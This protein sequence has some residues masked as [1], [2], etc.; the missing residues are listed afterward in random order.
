MPSKKSS[1]TKLLRRFSSRRV[2]SGSANAP[3]PTPAPQHIL[4]FI[5]H[6]DTTQLRGWV[7]S[8]TLGPRPPLSISIDG[9]DYPLDDVVSVERQDVAENHG[10]EYL[11]AGFRCE[12]GANLAPILREALLVGL[13]IQVRC[14]A[15]PLPILPVLRAPEQPLRPVPLAAS[16]AALA[17]GAVL[18]SWGHFSIRGRFRTGTPLIGCNGG[19]LDCRIIWR[20]RTEDGGSF[21]VELPGC[22]WEA[23][24]AGEDALLELRVDTGLLAEQPL[25]L[26]RTTAAEWI[27]DI[28]RMPDGTD[29]QY[30]ALLALEHTHFGAL[31]PLLDPETREFL[32]Q[33]AHGM[34]LDDYLS[35]RD[36]DAFADSDFGATAS[37]V[38][39]SA[40]IRELNERLCREPGRLFEHV[41]AVQE[42]QRLEGVPRRRFLMTCIAALCRS[43]ELEEL[44]SLIDFA[45]LY[46]HELSDSTWELSVVT[47]LMAAD[48]L[49][50]KVAETFARLAKSKSRDWLNTECIAFAVRR[51]QSLALRGEIGTD[52]AETLRWAFLALLDGFKGDW[53]SRL[54]DA[55]LIASMVDIL[56]VTPHCTDWR[57]RD[58]ADAAI[59]HYGLC[60]SFWEAL[61]ALPVQPLLPELARAR[62]LFSELQS[63]LVAP[64]EPS[65]A[66]IEGARQ[67]LAFFAR[68]NNVD[69]LGCS[70]E[71]LARDAIE[72]GGE[73][74]PPALLLAADLR[75]VDALES[76]RIAAF[77]GLQDEALERIPGAREGV[78]EAIRKV[79]ERP[80]S[81]MYHAQCAAH[82]L[83]RATSV[84]LASADADTAE[85]LLQR[86]AEYAF[87][88]SGSH[89]AALGVDL[90]AEIRHMERSRGGSG[91]RWLER[92]AQSIDAALKELPVQSFLPAAV[93]TAVSRIARDADSEY[94]HAFLREMRSLMRKRFG[95]R[96]DGI[97]ESGV[98]RATGSAGWLSDT[99]VVV[100]SCRKYLPGRVQ[101]IRDTWLRDLDARGIPWLVAVG[102]GEGALEADGVL[103]LAVSD[104]YEDLPLK[105]LAL[106]E[107]VHEHTD[108]Q[109]LL[110][111]DD[112]CYLDVERYFRT[113]SYRK[114]HYYGRTIRRGVGGTDRLWHQPKSQGEHA[115][116]SIDKSPEPSQYADGGAAYSLSR[117]AMSSLLRASRSER[118]MLLTGSSFMED[119]LVGDLL[120]MAQITVCSEDYEAC[121]RRRSFPGAEPVSMWEN[122]FFPSQITPVKVV[123]LDTDR[124]QALA[125][126]RSDQAVLWPKKLWPTYRGVALNGWSNQLE[127]LSDPGAALRALRHAPRVVAVMRNERLMLPHFLAHYRGLGV[128]CFIVVDNCSDDGTREYLLQEREDVVLFSADAQYK[129]SRFGVAWQQAV[130][131]NL[132]TDAWTVLADADEL[133][134]YPDC[135]HRPLAGF[136]EEVAADGSDCVLTYLIDMYPFGSL[137]E[138]DFSRAPPFEAAGWFEREPLLEWQ[139]GRGLYGNA[140]HYLSALRHRLA[141]EAEPHAFTA[142]KK[143]LLH[144]RPWMRFSQG[145]HDVANA[146]LSRRT[147]ALAHFKYHAGFDQKVR[148]EIRRKQHFNSA[149]EYRRYAD[150]LG[151]L[152]GGFGSEMHS[153]RYDGSQSFAAA[154]LLD[155]SK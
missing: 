87:A 6:L 111:I 84:S 98:A 50:A 107:W 38:L 4:G 69:A 127:L 7:I 110:K 130:L 63:M 95:R 42:H 89:G 144:Y 92:L 58:A 54:F 40:A 9:V 30:R 121:Q 100:Y 105:T 5:E 118:G 117:V 71:L 25:R 21:D 10:A 76:I 52:E 97:F 152:R 99:L 139:V 133:L 146:R 134:V 64:Q 96:H 77:P 53:F 48:G 149:E 126:E 8:Q 15:T 120:A 13:R 43:G 125:R 29:R 24:P 101:A 132:C 140:T 141:P 60:P 143:A 18:E 33:F 23:V 51:A 102:D 82:D 142:Q 148:T 138:A 49:F 44:R 56:R 17:H 124:D 37:T 78:L 26:A 12:P 137:G 88:L 106:V 68:K 103:G 59:R 41:R 35:A 45:P 80:G 39:V 70:R 150:M 34:G 91:E 151:E 11:H 115:R 90:L 112:D 123:H 86:L 36:A 128:R 94:A 135:E 61:D 32:T 28:A 114:H 22:L 85:S 3:G 47:A 74:S 46:S 67:A 73:L 131:G 55:S 147:A 57:Q 109:F 116:K 19:V 31:W 136:V 129:D 119:K 122:T 20:A 83:W 104:R 27:T 75:A 62:L 1:L 81:P 154:G 66:R 113:L 72:N 79:S 14:G 153:M 16:A 145:I 155:G 93:G 2:Q 108:A 65:A